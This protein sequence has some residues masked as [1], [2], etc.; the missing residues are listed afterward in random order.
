MLDRI[1]NA[2]IIEKYAREAQLWPHKEIFGEDQGLRDVKFY[3]TDGSFTVKTTGAKDIITPEQTLWDA[4]EGAGGIVLMPRNPTNQVLGLHI[5]SDKLQPGMN[6]YTWEL[7]TA[8][9]GLHLVKFMPRP[10]KG[11]SDC[12]SA[13]IRLNNAMLAFHDIQS[14]VTAGNLYCSLAGTNFGRQRRTLET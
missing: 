1:D 11:H 12:M 2:N 3:V 5:K 8:V 9:V 6:A 4:S 10:V 14:S 7:L 13:I